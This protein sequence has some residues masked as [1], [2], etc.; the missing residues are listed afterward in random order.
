V[1]AVLDEDRLLKL[2]DG[3]TGGRR[4][5]R[6]RL[7]WL[8]VEADLRTMGIKRWKLIAKDRT[9]WAGVIREAKALQGQ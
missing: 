6:P 2:F 1:C 4:T 5:G 3:K 7:R 9:E 8:D